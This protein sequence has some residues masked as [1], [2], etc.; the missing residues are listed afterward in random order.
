MV[1][2]RS[3]GKKKQFSGKIETVNVYEDNVLVVEALENVP[4]GSVIVVNGGGSNR[5]ALLGDRLAGIAQER[6]LSGIIINGSVR[7]SA[8]LANMDVGI[9]ALGTHPLKSRKLGKGERNSTL[10]FGGV[11]W[12]PGE[13]VYVDEDGVIVSK[14][15]LLSDHE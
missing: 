5:C 12:R 7:D 8:D 10:H 2:F 9:L 4:E 6:K 15:P 13:Y 11:E 1:P 3:F 14:Q